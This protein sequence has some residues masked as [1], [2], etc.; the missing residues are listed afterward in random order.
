MGQA[1][2]KINVKGRPVSEFRSLFNTTS[3]L[4]FYLWFSLAAAYFCS[5]HIR[6]VS[7]SSPFWTC[8]HILPPLIPIPLTCIYT[9][10]PWFYLIFTRSPLIISERPS[11]VLSVDPFLA[12]NRFP[13]LHIRSWWPAIWTQPFPHNVC[14]SHIPRLG[15]RTLFFLCGTHNTKIMTKLPFWLCRIDCW[16][17]CKVIYSRLGLDRTQRHILCLFFLSCISQRR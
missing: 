2:R 7:L 5:A 15:W 10:G 1:G 6:C 14:S 8:L 12:L 13:S 11:V 17:V 4:S 9:L 16:T 3:S